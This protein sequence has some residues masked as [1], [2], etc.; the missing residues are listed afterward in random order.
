MGI[1]NFFKNLL[2]K[3]NVD[4]DTLVNKAEG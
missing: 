2:G 1:L 3:A 4:V